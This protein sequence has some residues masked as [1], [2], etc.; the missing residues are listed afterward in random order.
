MSKYIKFLQ[1]N[2]SI[3]SKIQSFFSKNQNLNDYDDEELISIL[4]KLGATRKFAINKLNK[5]FY[6]RFSLKE[7]KEKQLQDVVI[8]ELNRKLAIVLQKSSSITDSNF[9]EFY[10]K[11]I[12]RIKPI[13]SEEG[14]EIIKD[15]LF[16]T[17]SGSTD[18][19]S[20]ELDIA[21]NNIEFENVKLFIKWKN[22]DDKFYLIDIEVIKK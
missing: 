17:R 15:S 20:K 22:M 14:L 13:F 18:I 11:L 12:K 16:I 2:K 9:K 4:M 1:E 19:G 8:A 7:D 10:T 5:R 3:D 21:I 6:G